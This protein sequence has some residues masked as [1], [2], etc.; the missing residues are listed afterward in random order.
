[1]EKTKDRGKNLSTVKTKGLFILSITLCCL[2]WGITHAEPSSSFCCLSGE[3]RYRGAPAEDGSKVAAFIDDILVA[4]TA[5]EDGEYYL[6][7][8][9]DDPNTQ[10]KDG[11][12]YEDIIVLKVNQYK[13]SPPTLASSGLI[14]H[15]ISVSSADA[16]S[17]TWG[18]IKALFK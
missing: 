11:W 2:L 3:V 5:A 14:I 8:P 16:P 9:E 7:I 17:T 1:M 13:A 6:C 15:N 18:K 4:Q 10:K 12:T